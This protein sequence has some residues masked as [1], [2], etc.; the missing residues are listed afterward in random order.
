MDE[1]L[2]R[3]GAASRGSGSRARRVDSMNLVDAES[4]G[5][6]AHT[7]LLGANIHVVEHLTD[8][9]SLPELGSAFT[10]S[11]PNV[12]G[13]GT[14]PV[15]R[16]PPPP[17][18]PAAAH[19]HAGQ[20]L[21]VGIGLAVG[22]AMVFAPSGLWWLPPA[23]VYALSIAFIAAVYIG[24]A[25][26]DGR[27]RI[28]GRKHRRRHLRCNRRARRHGITV[29]PCRRADR[30]RVQGP[31]AAPH[32]L[33]ARHQVV[34]TL[35][36]SR[37]LGRRR[38]PS[39]LHPHGFCSA[40]KDARQHPFPFRPH[41]QHPR[42][43]HPSGLETRTGVGVR[44]RA[45]ELLPHDAGLPHGRVRAPGQ[46]RRRWRKTRFFNRRNALNER[47]AR[48]SGPGEHWLGYQDSNL[49]QLNRFEYAVCYV[50]DSETRVLMR[51]LTAS[52]YR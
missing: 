22:V 25:V 52:V 42:R 36:R 43:T 45:S 41:R 34:A 35:L 51:M 9:G 1:A 5:R 26:A 46:G 3:S 13:M 7:S 32:R 12:A 39:H 8:P 31:L 11:P 6:P 21:P 40:V 4:R 16:M 29:V 50:I 49:E 20:S 14:F 2:P 38:H 23:T 28:C 33:R 37:R 18:P 27:Q 10:A 30:P 17:E 19:G 47:R 15:R 44:Q 48:I 24:F